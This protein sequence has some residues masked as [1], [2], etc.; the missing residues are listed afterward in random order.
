[1]FDLVGLRVGWV[2]AV[3]W[4][5]CLCRGFFM[6]LRLGPDCGGSSGGGAADIAEK[7][8]ASKGCWNINTATAE[9]LR[10]LPDAMRMCSA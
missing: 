9:Q 3:V 5:A 8:A 7:I 6:G 4:A 10:A 1:M 2:R